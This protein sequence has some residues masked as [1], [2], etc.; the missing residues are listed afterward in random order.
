MRWM[1]WALNGSEM[2]G[3]ASIFLLTGA[4]LRPWTKAE[5]TAILGSVIIQTCCLSNPNF[6]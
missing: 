1:Q 3:R 2:A 4:A 5:G 6:L